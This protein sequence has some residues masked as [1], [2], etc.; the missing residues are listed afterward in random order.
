M[1]VGKSL[2][3]PPQTAQGTRSRPCGGHV[4][5]GSRASGSGCCFPQGALHTHGQ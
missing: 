4:V 3:R 1:A 2:V 5:E